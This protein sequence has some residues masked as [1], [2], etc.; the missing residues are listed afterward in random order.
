[1]SVARDGHHHPSRGDI[2]REEAAS[3]GRRLHWQ[4]R[5]ISSRVEYRTPVNVLALR[6]ISRAARRAR[7]AQRSETVSESIESRVMAHMDLY[8]ASD[9][10][11][12]SINAPNR[13]ANSVLL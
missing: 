2:Q 9:R 10:R 6:W 11:Y 4:V 3:H 12:T 1:M 8:E 13:I 7:L 5:W